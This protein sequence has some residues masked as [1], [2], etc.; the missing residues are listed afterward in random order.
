MNGPHV[1]GRQS[2]IGPTRVE[3]SILTDIPRK[4]TRGLYFPKSLFSAPF[5]ALRRVARGLLLD[6]SPYLSFTE[7]VIPKVLIIDS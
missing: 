2:G 6:P 5:T 7:E 4:I 3:L 1:D